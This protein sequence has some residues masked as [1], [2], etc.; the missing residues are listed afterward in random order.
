MI[1]WTKTIEIKNCSQCPCFNIL[2]TNYGMSCGL[3]KEK[4]E[5]REHTSIPEFCPLLQ[6]NCLI[7][8]EYK[9]KNKK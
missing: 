7:K 8:I 1:R 4:K 2:D 3:M 5:I 6:N 9:P